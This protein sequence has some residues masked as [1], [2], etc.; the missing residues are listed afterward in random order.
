[1]KYI[2]WTFIIVTLLLISACSD[3]ET[4]KMRFAN[5][6]KEILITRELY[7]DTLKA[8]LEV[9][10]IIKKYGFTES[11]FKNKFFEYAQDRT[12]FIRLLDSVRTLAARTVDSLV[13][14][15]NSK[16]TTSHP[17][18]GNPKYDSIL[19]KFE[20]KRKLDSINK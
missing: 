4:E 12:E 5:T 19:K 18:M 10:K 8:N 17:M 16:P 3:S 9:K 15:E 2:Y 6:Y 11:E 14:E 1:M 20:M 7:A 13:P